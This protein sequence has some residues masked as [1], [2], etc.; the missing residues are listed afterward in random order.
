MFYSLFTLCNVILYVEMS[1]FCWLWLVY[2]KHYEVVVWGRAKNI[3]VPQN[4][5]SDMN[6]TNNFVKFTL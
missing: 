4:L 6:S 5:T 2:I 3:T 1:D